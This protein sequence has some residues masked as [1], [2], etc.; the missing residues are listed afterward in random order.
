MDLIYEENDYSDFEDNNDN[1][2]AEFPDWFIEE[3]KYMKK[4]EMIDFFK[5]HICNEPNF[6]GIK[7]VATSV[8]ANI[9]DSPIRTTNHIILTPYQETLM[10]NLVESFKG[11]KVTSKYYN[12]VAWKILNNCYI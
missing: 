4:L 1:D 7:N 9:L 8:I 6:I 11:V 10:E 2:V 5:K 3:E 12:Y